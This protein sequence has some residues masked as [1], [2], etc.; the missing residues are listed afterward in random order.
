MGAGFSIIE[1]AY[2]LS[3]LSDAPLLV[4]IIRGFGTAVMHAGV[5]GML[6]VLLVGLSDRTRIPGPGAWAVG[7]LVAIVLHAGFNRALVK[8]IHATA[9]VVIILPIALRQAYAWG[10]QRLRS[11]LG[12]GFDQDTELLDLIR[13][14]QVRDT[15]LGRYLVSLRATFRPDT[16]ADML[17]LLRLQAELSIRAKGILL[18]REHGLKPKPDPEI[19]ERLAELKWLEN[20][21]GKTGCLALRPIGRWQGRDRWQQY[22]L[23]EEG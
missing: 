3:N 17:C 5:T 6:S 15:P 4:W 19:A 21:I 23:E 2:Y 11:W 16:V 14:G 7:L 9:A 12:T 20:S 10:E 8:P 22:L 1:N 13:E 18:L